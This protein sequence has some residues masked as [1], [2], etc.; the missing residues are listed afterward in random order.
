[1]RFSHTSNA[2]PLPVKSI[3]NGGQYIVEA[4]DEIVLQAPIT[5]SVEPAP[6]RP[7]FTLIFVSIVTARY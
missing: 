4:K 1:M 7:Y 6:V 5:A 2:S 3:S